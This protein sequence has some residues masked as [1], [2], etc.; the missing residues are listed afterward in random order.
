[1]P[2]PQLAAKDSVVEQHN[3]ADA[4]VKHEVNDVPSCKVISAQGYTVSICIIVAT[5]T[6]G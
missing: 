6:L 2:F 3:L 5:S 1:M 4:D